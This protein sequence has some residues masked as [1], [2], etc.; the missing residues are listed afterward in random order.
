[1]R[2]IYKN[3]WSVIALLALIGCIEEDELTLGSNLDTTPPEFTELDTWI[4][5]NFTD[6]YNI[7]IIYKWESGLTDQT[8]YLFPP[9]VDSVRS[10]LNVVKKVWIDAYTDVGG[11]DFVKLIAPR[12]IVLIGGVNRNPSGTITLGT[13]EAGKRITLFN[14]N[15][16]QKTSR[17]S[18]TRFLETIQHEYTHILN[19]TKPFDLT[20]G[21][22]TPTGYTAQWFNENDFDSRMDGYITAYARSNPSEDFA[23]MVSQMLSR[24]NGEWNELIDDIG[25]TQARADIRSKEKI[26]VDYYEAELGIDFYVL[27]NSVYNQIIRL[28]E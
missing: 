8:R 14:A 25:S 6:P 19:Q 11:V 5:D 17:T 12:Q 13:A 27:Q 23:E 9:H 7:E 18:I 20:Y 28:T 24:D 2:H 26:V 22:I 15:L 21:E 3:I 4:K 16:V 10:L 1:M